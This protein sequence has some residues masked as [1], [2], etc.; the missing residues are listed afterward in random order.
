[1]S[2]DL[3]GI[4]C[5]RCKAYFFPEDDVVYC[6]D[7]G[8]PHHRECYNALGHCAL[9][10][11]H[12][13]ENEYK[14]PTTEEKSEP[15]AKQENENRNIITCKMC[16]EKYS[17]EEKRCPKCGKPDLGKMGLGEFDLLGGID[18]DYDFGD[19]VT[20]EDAKKFVGS[21]THRYI[22]KFTTLNK[23]NKVSWNW[24]AF[25]SPAGWFLSRKMYGKGIIAAMISIMAALLSFPF[26]MRLYSLGFDMSSYNM[27]TMQEIASRIG[28]IGIFFIIA[29]F[30]S[31]ALDV[32]V[33]I[34]TAL[35]GDYMY[36][37]HALSTIKKIKSE[38][39]DI[40]EDYRKKGG[41]NIFLYMIGII[42]VQYIPSF[43][44][45]LL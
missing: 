17:A 42:A 20:A 10:E 23:L 2:L 25:I 18:A 31:T 26:Q 43:V 5:V 4:S 33:R 19:G 40:D 30:A 38:S 15:Q 7:C 6:P 27:E 39:E 12:G 8:A 35:F 37:N 13:T 1:M 3:K 14:K 34:I 24:L 36:K 11:F 41:S 21:N 22:P 29:A 28:E 44:F 45:M 16:G 9:E 32:G